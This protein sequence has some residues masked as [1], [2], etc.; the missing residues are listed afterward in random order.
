MQNAMTDKK[1]D[2][3][4]FEF[5]INDKMKIRSWLLNNLSTSSVA[6][7]SIALRHAISSMDIP[8]NK[9]EEMI[10]FYLDIASE[11]QRVQNR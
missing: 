4:I 3:D 5:L 7:Y 10:R 2:N 1:K 6:N 9:K 11:S 8:Q